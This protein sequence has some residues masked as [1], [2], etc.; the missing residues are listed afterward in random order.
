MKAPQCSYRFGTALLVVLLW[1]GA[2]RAEPWLAP[3]DL[4]LRNDVQLL[5]DVGVL[6]GPASTWPLSWGD[7]AFGLSRADVSKLDAGARAAF[8]RLSEVAA[9]ETHTGGI[10]P[11][12]RGAIANDPR[13]LRTFEE[14][15]R[16]SEELEGGVAW[17]GLRMS[18][19]LQATVV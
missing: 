6:T 19:R 7:I 1:A 14:T 4:A 3:G 5:T 8:T 18:Y 12:L 16:E 2:S 13:I 10:T 15:P 11:V 9:R 17:T